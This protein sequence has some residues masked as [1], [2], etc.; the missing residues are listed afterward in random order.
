MNCQ[1][2]C[3]TDQ[4]YSWWNIHIEKKYMPMK[5]IPMCDLE[6]MV[7]CICKEVDKSMVELSYKLYLTKK[8]TVGFIDVNRS[9]SDGLKTLRNFEL[10]P[11][12][13]L[14][15]YWKWLK[16]KAE[17]SF[18]FSIKIYFFY[19]NIQYWLFMTVK[20]LWFISTEPNLILIIKTKKFLGK[21]N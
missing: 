1:H 3:D 6:Q 17:M 4:L 16:A 5:N 9:K 2:R 10:I 15:S 7:M 11:S 20:F 12:M 8:L 14:Y 18:L 13:S 19:I 21:V